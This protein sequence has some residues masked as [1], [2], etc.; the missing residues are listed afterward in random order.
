MHGEDFK[1]SHLKCCAVVG[2]CAALLEK[3]CTL[4][5][6]VENANAIYAIV[7]KYGWKNCSCLSGERSQ[8]SHTHKVRFLLGKRRRAEKAKCHF[9]RH[10]LLVK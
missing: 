1:Y 5:T 4:E 8:V 9:T 6:K 2:R 3:N 7:M 10:H